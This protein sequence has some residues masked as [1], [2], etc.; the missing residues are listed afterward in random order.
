MN[1]RT[2]M[3]LLV[4]TVIFGLGFAFYGFLMTESANPET[5]VRKYVFL[6]RHP[7]DALK[8]QVAKTGMYNKRNSEQY[9]V[10]GYFHKG[11]EIKFFYLRLNSRGWFVSS[12]E[13][14]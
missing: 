4:L 12:V 14:P 10:E 9:F 11:K 5:A 1:N 6:Q 3:V 7:I 8:I 13:G 2:K